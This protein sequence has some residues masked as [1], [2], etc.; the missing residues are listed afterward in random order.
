MKRDFDLIRK[1]L[2]Y[3]E[4]K[5]D[6]A[7][8]E[9]PEIKGYKELTIK[10]H[11]LLMA[12]AGFIDYEPEL[13]KTGRIIRVIAFSLT[14]EGHEFLDV[15]RNEGTWKRIKDFAKQKGA[16]LSF[17]VIKAIALHGVKKLIGS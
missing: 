3:F 17:D 11:I 2:F 13:T 6:T 8:V 7:S 4:E 1:L 15:I 14:W 9:C 12:Q 10:Y 16:S 5:P